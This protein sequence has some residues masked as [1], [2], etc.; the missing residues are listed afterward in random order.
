MALTF[1]LGDP[2]RPCGHAL[3]YF[4]DRDEGRIV[5]TYV[6]VL[7]IQMDM[8]KYLPPLLASQL[9]GMISESMGSP[10]NSLAVPPMPEVVESVAEL[11]RLAQIR[12]DDLIDGGTMAAS[13]PATAMQETAEAVHG[14]A[15]LYQQH[16][17]LQ[18]KTPE[19]HRADVPGSDDVQR[20]LYELMTERDRLA[21]LSKQVGMLRFALERSDSNLASEADTSME[22]LQELLPERYW[23]DKVCAAAHDLSDHGATLARLYLE[24]CY[25]LLDE[26]YA[27]VEEIERQIT[28]AEGH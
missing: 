12:S 15:G 5:A 1:D 4:R 9:G 16:L 18:P 11:E 20:V 3:L 7:P 23:A 14:Y 2:Q 25:K 8:G 17:A 22:A 27:A 21:E 19:L 28:A 10:M 6:L 13:D 26:Q 24:R